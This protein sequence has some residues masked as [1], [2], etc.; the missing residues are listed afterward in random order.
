MDKSQKSNLIAA[1]ILI[2]VMIIAVILAIIFFGD[3]FSKVDN[4]GQH[5]TLQLTEEE[6]QEIQFKDQDKR[7]MD[8]Y[9][10]NSGGGP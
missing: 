1:R 5:S 3:G 8:I 10:Q 7:E 4:I 9:K 6:R 2:A